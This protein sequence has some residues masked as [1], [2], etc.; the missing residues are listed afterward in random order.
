[1]V[2]LR[3]K[4]NGISAESLVYDGLQLNMLHKGRPMFQFVRF[5]RDRIK[6]TLLHCAKYTQLQINLVFTRDSSESLVYGVLPLNVLH[7]GRLMF[8]LYIFIKETTRIVAENSSTAHD[9]FR[10]SWGSSD[11]FVIGK[12]EEKYKRTTNQ[13]IRNALLIRLLKILRQP[14]TGFALLGAHQ[15]GAVP[16]FPST[17]KRHKPKFGCKSVVRTRP[18]PLDFPCLGLGNEGNIPTLVLPSGGMALPFRRNFYRNPEEQHNIRI[19]EWTDV[20]FPLPIW[21]QKLNVLH[22]A[23][24]CFSWYDFRDIAIHV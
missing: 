22:Q 16:E 4:L 24:S 2:A 15:V 12:R 11:R 9:R 23:A 14:T 18:L 21:V 3:Q 6:T 5:T 20:E 13:C 17:C 7:T 8:Q 1:M 19:S 10:P